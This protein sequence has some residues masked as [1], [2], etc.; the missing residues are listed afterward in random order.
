MERIY[1]FIFIHMTLS[2]FPLLNVKS[3][4]LN[5]TQ[6]C[7]SPNAVFLYQKKSVQRKELV[8]AYHKIKTSV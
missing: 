7:Q 5:Q 3:V 6:G 1:T 2:A 4:Q 8:N